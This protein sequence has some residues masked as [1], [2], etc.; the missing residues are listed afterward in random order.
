MERIAVDRAVP[1]H[2]DA[3]DVPRFFIWSGMRTYVA[4]NHSE[5][6]FWF[7]AVTRHWASSC[8]P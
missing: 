5:D 7:L 2:R 6:F 1:V 8:V 3:E 4:A